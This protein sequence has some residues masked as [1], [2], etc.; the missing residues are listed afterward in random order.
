MKGG[1]QMNFDVL[2]QHIM[3]EHKTEIEALQ[4]SMISGVASVVYAEYIRNFRRQSNSA[5]HIWVPSINNLRHYIGAHGTLTTGLTYTYLNDIL[6]NPLMNKYCKDVRYSNMT[7]EVKESLNV[8][9]NLYIIPNM[10]RSI[11]NSIIKKFSLNDD[12]P[13]GFQIFKENSDIN[14]FNSQPISDDLYQ[15]IVSETVIQLLLLMKSINKQVCIPATSTDNVIKGDQIFSVANVNGIT[16][17]HI[18]MD[19]IQNKSAIELFTFT[20][21]TQIT[22]CEDSAIINTSPFNQI[23]ITEFTE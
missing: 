12:N 23:S 16:P 3:E 21:N 11:V 1:F 13:N 2:I 9:F 20:T 19:L 5:D 14:M 6:S 22:I 15:A 4:L 18:N 17:I 7:N 8:I 10:T